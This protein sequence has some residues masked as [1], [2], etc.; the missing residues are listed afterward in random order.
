M[1]D[2]IGL[3][4]DNCKRRNYTTTKNKKRQPD[5]L[6]VR[7]FCPSCRTHTPHKESKI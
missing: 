6:G 7:K 3:A 4:C 1:R 2:L 5:K